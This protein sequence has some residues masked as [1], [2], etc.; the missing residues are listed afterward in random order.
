M[1]EMNY[2]SRLIYDVFS[3]ERKNKWN[4]LIRLRNL[5]PFGLGEVEDEVVYINIPINKTVTK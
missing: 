3:E 4:K 1:K 5:F 2:Y